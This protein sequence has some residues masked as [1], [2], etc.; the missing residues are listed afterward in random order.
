MTDILANETN[1][2][3]L[4]KLKSD[5]SEIKSP[6][7][8]SFFRHFLVHSADLLSIVNSLF[9]E[10]NNSQ[11]GEND[12]KSTNPN[13]QEEEKEKEEEEEEEKEEEKE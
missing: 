10:M 13:T 6:S 11:N 5:L 9:N 7:R 1:K 3:R 4:V 2:D 8:H 12:N